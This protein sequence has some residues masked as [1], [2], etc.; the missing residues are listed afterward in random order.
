MHE[1]SRAFA[2]RGL[3]YGGKCSNRAGRF[4]EPIR[5]DDI[6]DRAIQMCS[7]VTWEWTM[8]ESGLAFRADTLWDRLG[9]IPDRRGRKGRQYGKASVMVLALAAML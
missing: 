5:P 1:R 2:R 7:F 9:A 6:Q 4:R 8:A 3:S